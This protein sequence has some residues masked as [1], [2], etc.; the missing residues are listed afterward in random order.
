MKNFG[1]SLLQYNMEN[2]R[3]PSTEEGLQELVAKGLMKKIPEDPWGNPYNY[4]SPGESDPEYEIW[5][6]GAD[7]KAGGDG[8]DADINSWE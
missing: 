6:F 1:T 2:G 3:F 7:G 5:S 4:R 8:F